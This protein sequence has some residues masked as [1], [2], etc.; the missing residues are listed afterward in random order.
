MSTQLRRILL[1]V[2]ALSA[3]D[4]G[5][6]AQFAPASFYREFPGPGMHWLT[7]LGPYNEH[8]IRDVGGL[9]LALLV[10]TTGALVR[11]TD[12]YLVRVC[13]G[14]W[15]VFSVGHLAF[16]LA[17]LGMY[18]TRDQ[19]LNVVALGGTLLIA[20]A[21]LLSPAEARRR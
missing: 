4:V 3:A 13:A 15:A 18:G 12:A 2:L 9:Y 19:L 16:H 11:A 5:I 8:L 10:M 7:V 6:W 20:I 14:A 1:V 21:L 17:H